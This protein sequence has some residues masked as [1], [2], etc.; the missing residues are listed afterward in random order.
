M[1]LS[2]L[3]IIK[4]FNPCRPP[5]KLALLRFLYTWDNWGT[6]RVC[7][8][9][10]VTQLVSARI[11]TWAV[12]VQSPGPH[13]L[14]RTAQEQCDDWQKDSRFSLS[15]MSLEGIP[16]GQ[17]ILRHCKLVFP[18]VRNNIEFLALLNVTWNSAKI[19]LPLSQSLKSWV[20]GPLVGRHS[21]SQVSEPYCEGHVLSGHLWLPG[22]TTAPESHCH[23]LSCWYLVTLRWSINVW[24]I[25]I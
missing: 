8:L 23:L 6:E 1:L 5:V 3:C 10:K 17:R 11:W 2:V 4:P 25:L 24:K 13:L 15:T 9:A 22:I 12:S 18:Y 20:W 16:E 19:K 21:Q 14:Y 7:D